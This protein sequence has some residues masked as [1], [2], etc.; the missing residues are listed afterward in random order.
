M[1]NHWVTEDN[2]NTMYNA[3]LA[4]QTVLFNKKKEDV[5]K[6]VLAQIQPKFK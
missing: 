6:S 4:S 2:A 3:T 1:R 5:M